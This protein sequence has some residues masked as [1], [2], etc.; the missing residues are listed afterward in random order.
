MRRN[1]GVVLAGLLLLLSGCMEV[2]E[3]ITI[4]RDGSGRSDV[5]IVVYRDY[6]ALVVPALREGFSKH[7]PGTQLKVEHDQRTG[8]E[9]LSYSI[10]FSDASQIK[11][12][13]KR[14]SLAHASGGLFQTRYTFEGRASAA[15]HSKQTFEAPKFDVPIPFEVTVRLPGSIDQTNGEKV[16]SN[17]VRW[18]WVGEKG[19]GNLTVTSTAFGGPDA[20]RSF[21]PLASDQKGGSSSTYADESGLLDSL[22][23]KRYRVFRDQGD[24]WLEDQDG[25]KRTLIHKVSSGRLLASFFVVHE[26]SVAFSEIE[27]KAAA[28]PARRYFFVH[29]VDSGKTRGL[30]FGP[31]Y[32]TI[33][34]PRASRA[35][36]ARKSG[37]GP[38]YGYQ[39]LDG[40][41]FIVDLRTDARTMLPRKSDPAFSAGSSD[42]V[43]RKCFDRWTILSPDEDSFS[44]CRVCR[45]VGRNEDFPEN[46]SF[47]GARDQWAA[48]HFEHKSQRLTQLAPLHSNVGGKQPVPI[49]IQGDKV[50]LQSLAEGSLWVH[51]LATQRS[52]Y[53]AQGAAGAT[54]SRDRTKIAYLT[55]EEGTFLL[56]ILDVYSGR[57]W[58]RD[59]GRME[60]SITDVLNWSDDDRAIYY[61]SYYQAP[62]PSKKWKFGFHDGIHEGQVVPAGETSLSLTGGAVVRVPRFPGVSPD[63]LRI[64]LLALAALMMTGA[65]WGGYR[66]VR[67]R[68]AVKSASIATTPQ[69]APAFCTRCGTAIEADAAFCNECGSRVG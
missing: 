27:D 20:G 35:V 51:D 33:M 32:N 10:E 18:Q 19:G 12:G 47:D 6:A 14:Y 30:D 9:I 58:A 5:T 2:K 36:I 57:K 60:D 25:G 15:E 31:D 28:R 52:T 56:N 61:T 21:G 37:P 38:A 11:E 7:M 26:G 3:N 64:A 48:W 63:L 41:S 4:N 54:A 42:G 45:A 43:G 16:D 68:K 39:L 1:L 69:R 29:E 65:L 34:F 62:N 55:K 40:E 23:Y 46:W 53:V 50:Y 13:L 59:I 66:I 44:F 67:R 49:L 17:A 22:L 24:L 8:N